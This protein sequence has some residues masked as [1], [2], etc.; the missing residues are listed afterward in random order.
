MGKGFKGFYSGEVLGH[1]G[2]GH[3]GKI[4]FIF[5]KFRTV[6]QKDMSTV[7]NPTISAEQLAEKAEKELRRKQVKSQKARIRYIENREKI[8]A[9]QAVYDAEKRIKQNDG[10]A[11]PRGRPRKPV[12]EDVIDAKP[13]KV[14][15]PN[16]PEKPR[17]RP[18]KYLDPVV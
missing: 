1:V 18:R 13:V 2:L 15:D 8:L 14:K 11:R 10:V 17:G 3:V 7:E 5:N 4:D 12:G 6:I 16:I 9:R